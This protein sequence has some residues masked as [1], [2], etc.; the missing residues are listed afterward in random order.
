MREPQPYFTRGEQPK[1][2]CLWC[3]TQKSNT[4][5]EVKNEY[6]VS[7][8]FCSEDCKAAHSAQDERLSGLSLTFFGVVILTWAAVL[9]Y[10]DTLVGDPIHSLLPQASLVIDGVLVLGILCVFV[11]FILA[12]KSRR[13]LEVRKRVP[14]DSKLE[15][16]GF[17]FKA[18]RGIPGV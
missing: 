3:G 8:Y 13:G 6:Q 16:K 18:K 12:L 5:I 11:S 2:I 14:K 4:W 17:A 1:T 15:A 9:A 10:S 7:G